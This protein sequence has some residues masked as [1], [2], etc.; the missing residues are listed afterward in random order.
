[1]AIPTVA[2]SLA[3]RMETL[4]L[5]PLSQSEIEGLSASWIDHAFAGKILSKGVDRKD[6]PPIFASASS[7]KNKL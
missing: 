7:L 3:G 5:L 4:S 1:M 6:K 2:D